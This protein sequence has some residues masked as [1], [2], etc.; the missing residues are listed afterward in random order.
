[1]GVEAIEFLKRT[2]EGRSSFIPRGAARRAGAAAARSSY[3][4]SA[5]VVCDATGDTASDDVGAVPTSPI[6]RRDR[7]RLAE[8]RRRARADAGAHR[9]R[10]Q[11]DEVAT[12]LLGD[13][14]VVEDLERALAL[15]RETQTDEDHRHA[16][17]RGDRSAGRRHR[18]L[19]RVG[20]GGRAR[21]EA[22]DPR[23][24]GG[25]GAARRRPRGGAGAPRR[26]QA[27]GRRSDA[28]RSR[29][30]AAALRADEMALFGQQKDLDRAIRGAARACEARR[31]QLAAQRGR[32]AARAP[33]RTSGAWRRRRR[34][35]RTTR[36]RSTTAERA[37]GE[38][39]ARTVALADE[40]DVA[41]AEL[42]DAKVAA[43]QAE[44][45]RQNARADAGAAARRA[46]PTTRR[47]RRASRRRIAEDDGARRR[48][49]A[50]DARAPA[51]RGGAV[52]GRGRG[53]RA[54]PR[55]AAGRARG[56]AGARSPSAR[57]EL[58]A[59]RAEVARL[60]QTLSQ[61]ELRCQEVDAAPDVARGARRRALP[62]RR[63]GE[64]RL[65]LPPAA[66]GR[67]ERGD[68]ARASC[69]TSS[70]AWARST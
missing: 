26:A 57:R 13:V 10:P 42:T 8:G 65:R 48:R 61:L 31:A 27:G 44:E 30:L 23:A 64:R 47:A 51:R 25:D 46:R 2:S 67:R 53:A 5:G 19:A 41:V 70:S 18:R 50:R 43:A 60:A 66:A 35:S 55:R 21:A 49:C 3:D 11:Y 56:A 54:R 69:A 1:M 12:Y 4:A 68:S 59:A 22:R 28:R 34:R 14:L 16:R 24:R 62:R 36:A 58:R 52:A 15:W 32:S 33:T 45:R 6:D 17:R 40:V 63:A 9:L 37:R 39:R 38:L 29:R 20:A 7:R